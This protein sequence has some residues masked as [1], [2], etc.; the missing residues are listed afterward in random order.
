MQPERRLNVK[1]QSQVKT[2]RACDHC[3]LRRIKCDGSLPCWRCVTS[4]LN[5]SFTQARKRGPKGAQSTV[6]LHLKQELKYQ[7]VSVIYTGR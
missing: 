1:D 3:K 5:C 2:N 7:Q 4:G 6:L